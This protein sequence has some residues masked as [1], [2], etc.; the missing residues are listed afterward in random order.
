M[1]GASGTPIVRRVAPELRPIRAPTACLTCGASLREARDRPIDRRAPRAQRGAL[2]STWK[3]KNLQ[4][5]SETDFLSFV[6]PLLLSI[7][8]SIP[9][10]LLSNRKSSRPNSR[11]LISEA[12]ALSGAYEISASSRAI[13]SSSCALSALWLSMSEEWRHITDLA[14]S[15]ECA[16]FLKPRKVDEC[17]S[18]ESRQNPSPSE[19]YICTTEVLGF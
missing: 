5:V 18:L 4:S 6:F 19:P 12:V 15:S 8:S 11:V 1:Q 13:S 9:L 10:C 2:A 7:N 16:G 17:Q 3:S 14:G